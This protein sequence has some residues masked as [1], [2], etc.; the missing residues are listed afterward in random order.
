[1]QYRLAPYYLNIYRLR[2]VMAKNGTTWPSVAGLDF[3]KRFVTT[4]EGIDSNG[5][6]KLEIHDG[7]ASFTD[8][9]STML[10]AEI[11]VADDPSFLIG[12]RSEDLKGVAPQLI[13]DVTLYPSTSGRRK[14]AAQPGWGCPCCVS[15]DSPMVGYDGW[16][17][18]GDLALAPGETRQL[19]FVFLS[20]DEAV[21]QFRKSGVFYPWEGGFIGEAKVVQATR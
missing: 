8:V 6:V 18:L 17:L 16:P 1:M 12:G 21:A 7:V 9:T 19:G 3:Y 4:L 11:R 2:L 20:G 15:K 10:L 5:P 13:A 14:S